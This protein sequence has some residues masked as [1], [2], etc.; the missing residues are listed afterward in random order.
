MWH[1]SLER[2]KGLSR[3]GVRYEGMVGL[4]FVQSFDRRSA[5][6]IYCEIEVRESE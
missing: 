3:G 2:G 5:T 6:I 4:K 1:F